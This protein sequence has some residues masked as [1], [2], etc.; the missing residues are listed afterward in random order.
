V[1]PVNFTVPAGGHYDGPV[2]TFTDLGPNEG[3]DGYTA[4]TERQGSATEVPATIESAGGNSYVV[5][6]NLDY[7]FSNPGTSNLLVGV[8]DKDEYGPNPQGGG[9]V[10]DHVNVTA[11]Q[12]SGYSTSVVGVVL[13]SSGKQPADPPLAILYTTDPSITSPN[14]VSVSVGAPANSNTPIPLVTDVALNRLSNGVTQIV[15]NGVVSAV[16]PGAGP[17]AS[18]P[19]TITVGN[20]SPLTTQVVVN[21]TLSDYIVNPVEFNALAGQAVQNV[22][23]AT[24]AGPGNGS[25]S[26]TINWGDGDTSTGIITAVGGGQFS[27]SGSKPHPYAITGTY[28]ITVNVN[29]PGAI[30]APAAQTIANVLSTPVSPPPAPPPSPP[31]SSPPAS[32]P[33]ASAPPDNSAPAGASPPGLSVVAQFLARLQQFLAQIEATIQQLINAQLAIVSNLFRSFPK[34]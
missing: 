16:Q 8:W 31:P 11:P 19:L 21:Q 24:L 13:Q 15:I 27:V 12:L 5:Y 33:S 30:P 7:S 20:E 18:A 28:R 10:T 23:V 4:W 26:A 17:V 22:Q 9:V 3:P 1:N 2:A 6:A 25:Y 32:P 29:G 14:Q 34:V